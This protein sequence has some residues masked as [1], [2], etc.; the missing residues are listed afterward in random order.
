VNVPDDDN[1]TGW[2]Y[3]G[4]TCFASA[5]QYR[6]YDEARWRKRWGVLNDYDEAA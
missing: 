2:R 3:E 6:E 4:S 5:Q 1:P